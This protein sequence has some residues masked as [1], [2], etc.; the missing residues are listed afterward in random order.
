MPRTPP[1]VRPAA[2]RV[3]RVVVDLLGR[4]ERPH[5]AQQE[6]RAHERA[7]PRRRRLAVGRRGCPDRGDDRTDLGVGERIVLLRRHEEERPSVRGDAMADRPDQVEAAGPIEL[8]TTAGEVGLD[9]APPTSPNARQRLPAAHARSALDVHPRLRD[10]VPHVAARRMLNEVFIPGLDLVAPPRG[11]PAPAR[12]RM[13]R[14]AGR[15]DRK[16]RQSRGIDIYPF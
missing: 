8:A 11:A 2:A 15:G 7:D 9:H 10:A 4:H 14:P 12:G 6:Q 13:V 5:L 16:S 1:W 3:G